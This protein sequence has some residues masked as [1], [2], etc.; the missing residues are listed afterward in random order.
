[1]CIAVVYAEKARRSFQADDF[2]GAGAGGAEDGA[3]IEGDEG[4]E[5]QDRDCLEKEKDI[6]EESEFSSGAPVLPAADAELGI[7]AP[8][9]SSPALPPFRTPR[10]LSHIAPAAGANPPARR[11]TDNTAPARRSVG[12]SAAIHPLIDRSSR[13]PLHN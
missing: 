2:C 1:Q 8:C 7:R 4:F 12:R 11:E 13:S 3:G 5:R 9:D 6:A 10:A